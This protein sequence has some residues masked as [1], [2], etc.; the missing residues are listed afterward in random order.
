MR[1]MTATVL[2]L[3]TALSLASIDVARLTDSRT[4]A[5]GVQY[6]WWGRV[7]FGDRSGAAVTATVDGTT[8]Y[9]VRLAI[10]RH[11]VE[12]DCTCPAGNEGAFCK[13][14]VAVALGAGSVDLDDGEAWEHRAHDVLDSV[15][16]LLASRR[17]S[18]V[19]H[20]CE[21]AGELIDANAGD[22]RDEAAVRRLTNRVTDLRRRAS[23]PGPTPTR[24]A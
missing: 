14:L 7:H 18:D 13:H 12:H 8:P 24:T 3:P 23:L 19:L 1:A 16:E 10:G 4:Y 9:A 15:E 11:G 17:R 21:L 6:L 20:F 2:H 22:I 5:R